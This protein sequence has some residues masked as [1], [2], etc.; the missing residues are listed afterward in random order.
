VRP[1]LPFVLTSTVRP[2]QPLGR[3][4]RTV[5]AEACA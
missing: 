5:F 4:L 1:P 2:S 3:P